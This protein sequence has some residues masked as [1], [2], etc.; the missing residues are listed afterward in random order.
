MES[1][2]V[3]CFVSS[4]VGYLHVTASAVGIRTVHFSAN[5]PEPTA[6]NEHVEQC[7]RQL[8]EYFNGQRKVFDLSLDLV[9]TSFQVKV[10]KELMNIPFGKTISY[11]ELAKRLGDEKVIRAAA[12]ANG[13][14]PVAILVPCHRVIGSNGDLV[15]YAGGLHRKKWLLEFEAG[16]VQGTLF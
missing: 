4:P 5:R 11:L 6:S 9:G 10:W 12:S 14:N 13:S 2:A 1:T 16:A 3:A 15:G 7:I 8:D